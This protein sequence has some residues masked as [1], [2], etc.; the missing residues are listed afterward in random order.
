M[1]KQREKSVS[2]NCVKIGNNNYFV[3]YFFSTA[4]LDLSVK[5]EI[6]NHVLFLIKIL[7]HLMNNLESKTVY[8]I[9]LIIV[10]HSKKKKKYI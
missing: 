6:M 2:L 10:C 4:K 7:F 3:R 5:I 1:I 8:E 9:N